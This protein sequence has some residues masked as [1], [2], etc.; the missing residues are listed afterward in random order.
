MLKRTLPFLSA[1][2]LAAA[3]S[4]GSAQ[5]MPL[6]ASVGLAAQDAPS[7]VE[8][9]QW[10]DIVTIIM[11]G[12]TTT[13]TVA[14]ATIITGAITIITTGRATTAGAT[15]ITTTIAATITTTEPQV[16]RGKEWRCC[17]GRTGAAAHR[18]SSLLTVG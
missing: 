5:A 14:G 17:V 3:V 4:V 16:L 12:V 6:G 13:I 2:A 18:P 11:A 10:W 15:T 9:V 7:T 8:Q 1:L